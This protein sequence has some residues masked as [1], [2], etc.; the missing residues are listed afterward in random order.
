MPVLVPDGE[1]PFVFS[2]SYSN[3][4]DVPIVTGPPWAKSY[5]VRVLG[6]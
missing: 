5:K 4:D 6:L 1:V 2:R 3:A